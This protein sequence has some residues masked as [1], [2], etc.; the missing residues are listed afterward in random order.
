MKQRLMTG[1]G[2]TQ[3]HSSQSTRGGATNKGIGD[4][5]R[6]SIEGTV[7]GSTNIAMAGTWTWI[8][9]MY[10]LIEDG[11]VPLLSLFTRE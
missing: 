7:P 2:A 1:M 5:Q 6:V 10:F 8:Q 9:S 11:D 3:D 4:L